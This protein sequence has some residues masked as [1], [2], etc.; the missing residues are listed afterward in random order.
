MQLVELL[1]LV[2]AALWAIT[3]VFVMIRKSPYRSAWLLLAGLALIFIVWSLFAV[4]LEGPF[5]FWPEH[6]RN[7]WGNQI[8]FDLLLAIGISWALLVPQAKS[9]NMNPLP[10]LI[11]IGC[12]GSIG[13]LAMYSRLLYLKRR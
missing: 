12:T 8:W 3:A 1:P 6:T 11:L 10:W 2:A 13:V 7:L 9:L 4:V 5:G